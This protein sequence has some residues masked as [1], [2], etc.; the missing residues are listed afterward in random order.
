MTPWRGM[1]D[2][3]VIEIQKVRRSMGMFGNTPVVLKLRG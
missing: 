2:L 1:S 3:A